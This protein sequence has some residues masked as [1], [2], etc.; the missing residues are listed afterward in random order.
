[1]ATKGEEQ[2]PRRLK[3]ADRY[4]AGWR[5]GAVVRELRVPLLRRGHQL[6]EAPGRPQALEKT[7][8][9]GEVHVVH[10]AADRDRMLQPAQRL[11]RLAD[12][13]VGPGHQVRP[14]LV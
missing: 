8:V 7:I 11:V 5:W 1:M 4:R 13:R 6:L 10:P 2:A 3:L 14:V 9:A 12:Q